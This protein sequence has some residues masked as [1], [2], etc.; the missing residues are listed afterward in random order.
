MSNHFT[1]DTFNDDFNYHPSQT[2]QEAIE[3]IFQQPEISPEQVKAL[4][5]LY[6]FLQI[7]NGAMDESRLDPMQYRTAKNGWRICDYGEAIS[8][9]NPV[10]LDMQDESL[11]I[12]ALNEIEDEEDD[13]GSSGNSGDSEGGSGSVSDDDE[14][15]DENNSYQGPRTKKGSGSL[16]SQAFHTAQEMIEIAAAR[17]WEGVIIVD[18]HPVMKR[19]AWMACEQHNLSYGGFK[20]E[21]TDWKK[22]Q[23]IAQLDEAHVAK[24]ISQLGQ[25]R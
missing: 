2:K 7:V 12:K 13:E 21:E 19:A 17:E 16:I 14:E 5:N 1:S 6:P 11:I 18:G 10:Y 25:Q 9:S 3:S 4:L 22:F 8:S 24:I 20:P 15:L 23:R